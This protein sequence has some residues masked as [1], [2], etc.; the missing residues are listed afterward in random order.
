[1]FAALALFSFVPFHPR[2][3]AEYASFRLTK[4]DYERLTV[5]AATVSKAAANPASTP[6]SEATSK[7]DAPCSMISL[8]AST[9]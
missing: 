4:T 6:N 9:A 7:S 8:R 1:M 3:P 2:G 5:T